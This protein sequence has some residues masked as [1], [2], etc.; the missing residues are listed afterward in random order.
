MPLYAY[1]CLE[2]SHKF[3]IIATLKEVYSSTHVFEVICPQCENNAN[4]RLISRTTFSL[5][6]DGW[7]KDGYSSKSMK[8]DE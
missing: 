1:E 5:K 4:R 7:Y 3:E 6:G 2:C 8:N